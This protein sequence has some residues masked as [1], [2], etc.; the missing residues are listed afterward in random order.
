MG[1][2]ILKHN[3]ER[4]Q[5]S[6]MLMGVK[7]CFSRCSLASGFTLCK[8]ANVSMANDETARRDG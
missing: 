1:R 6:V 3:G 2:S 8:D 4:H 7:Y 5:R